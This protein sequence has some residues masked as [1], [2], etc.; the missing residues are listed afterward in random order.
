MYG[1]NIGLEQ[2]LKGTWLS[3]K[4]YTRCGEEGKAGTLRRSS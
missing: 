4:K 1:V 3:C 2:E